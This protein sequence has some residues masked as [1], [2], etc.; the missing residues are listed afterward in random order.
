MLILHIVTLLRIEIILTV[1]QIATRMIMT[2]IQLIK[3]RTIIVI[4]FTNSIVL[5][6]KN[7]TFLLKN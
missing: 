4:Q 6:L 3:I 2:L 1:L 5:P 7:R